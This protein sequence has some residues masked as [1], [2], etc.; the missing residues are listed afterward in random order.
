LVSVPLSQ[1]AVIVVF[2]GPE[3]DQ[4][5]LEICVLISIP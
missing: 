2:H 3:I 4:E 5:S 1:E